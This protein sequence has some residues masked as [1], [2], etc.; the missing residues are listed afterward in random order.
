M[1]IMDHLK[2]LDLRRIDPELVAKHVCGLT[3]V[4]VAEIRHDVLA[5]RRQDR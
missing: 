1:K 5:L 4:S 3:D 2:N